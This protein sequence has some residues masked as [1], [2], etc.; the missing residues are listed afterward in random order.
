[1]PPSE[2]VRRVCWWPD[3]VD[4]RRALCALEGKQ[5]GPVV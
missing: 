4:S 5:V 2:T 3:M 1:M